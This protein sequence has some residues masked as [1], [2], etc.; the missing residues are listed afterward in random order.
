MYA[1][2]IK[3]EVETTNT[4]KTKFEALAQLRDELKLQVH[5]AKADLRDEWNEKLEPK[6]WELKSKL[7]HLEEAS[8]ET[9]IELQSAM[10]SLMVELRDGYERIRK[11]L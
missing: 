5:L 11:S 7:G 6:F 4:E 1:E 9:A 10:K 8:V 3:P 2:T